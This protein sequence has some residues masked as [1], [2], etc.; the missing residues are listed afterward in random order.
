MSLRS[1]WCSIWLQDAEIWKD[2]DEV[3]F[4]SWMDLDEGSDA[5]RIGPKTFPRRLPYQP[6]EKF[7]YQLIVGVGWFLLKGWKD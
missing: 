7:C 5:I 3:H 1:L 2:L 4:P 6:T